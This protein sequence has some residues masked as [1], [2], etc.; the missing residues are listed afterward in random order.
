MWR[1]RSL[2]LVVLLPA[3]ACG[4]A[5]G[6]NS[7]G[8]TADETQGTTDTMTGST[9]PT[10]TDDSTATDGPTEDGTG[11]DEGTDDTDTDSGTD[12]GD[13]CGLPEC[14]LNGPFGLHVEIPVTWEAAGAV[15]AGAGEVR[16]TLRA[17]MGTAGKEVSGNAEVCEFLVPWYDEAGTGEKIELDWRDEVFPSS[18]PALNIFGTTCGDLPDQTFEFEAIPV[19]IGVDLPGP[20][21]GAWPNDYQSIPDADHDA[22]GRPAF[23][24]VGGATS[25]AFAPALDDAKV[26]RSKFMYIAA[27]MVAAA[28]GTL[29]DCDGGTG[30]AEVLHLDIDAVGCR[31]C[32]G[33][34]PDD[35]VDQAMDCSMQQIE[36]LNGYAGKYEIG[37]PTFKFARI[38]PNLDC[39]A[40]ATYF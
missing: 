16:V 37:M 17:V 11:T 18:I 35:C 24:V 20:V 26:D 5:R 15:T 31:V 40:V 23:S 10:D 14:K 39:E 36:Y 13:P 29:T 34:Q 4:D 32:Q 38:D 9:G 8:A 2:A 27:R 25:N 12:T 21:N 19:Q 22:D 33:D 30:D 28:Q 3:F 7:G 6:K 1:T